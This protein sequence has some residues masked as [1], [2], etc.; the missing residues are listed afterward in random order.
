MPRD[1][2]EGSL[3]IKVELLPAKAASKGFQAQVEYGIARVETALPRLYMLAQGGTDVGTG[4]NT[5]IGFA[6]KVRTRG[7]LQVL[8][9]VGRCLQDR[10]VSAGLADAE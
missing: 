5:K 8:T 3:A 1:A 7:V 6:E 10:Q 4:L 2:E 9:N